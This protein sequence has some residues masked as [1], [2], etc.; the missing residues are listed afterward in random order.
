MHYYSG[1]SLNFICYNFQVCFSCKCLNV[2]LERQK[3]V[4]LCE[5][6][7]KQKSYRVETKS[8]N[9]KKLLSFGTWP[10]NTET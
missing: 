9:N 4:D 1:E 5:F 7:E 8:Q 3:Q 6:K 2:S 10:F